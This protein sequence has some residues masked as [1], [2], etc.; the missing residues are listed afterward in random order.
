[1]WNPCQLTPSMAPEATLLFMLFNKC[2][3]STYLHGRL[4]SNYFT[5]RNS[6]SR[7]ILGVYK[8]Q[9][10]P[11][12]KAGDYKANL[13]GLGNAAVCFLYWAFWSW[14]LLSLAS[15]D[16]G[17]L[18]APTGH[19]PEPP[20][21]EAVPGHAAEDGAAAGPLQGLPG[22]P[23][24]SGQEEGCSGHPG[25]CQGHGCSAE[26]PAAESQCRWSPSFLGRWHWLWPKCVRANGKN[27]WQYGTLT[28][29]PFGKCFPCM[30]KV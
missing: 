14:T 10:S 7:L 4:C 27:E 15:I 30:H 23:A 9:T 8:F 11:I 3:F 2:L 22:A 16:P 21:D 5:N 19:C 24:S 25:A 1:M 26:L 17:G 12:T 20:A 18:W 28:R 13:Q 29:S 6:L